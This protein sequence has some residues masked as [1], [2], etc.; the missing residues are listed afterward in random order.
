MM[1]D[2]LSKS[3]YLKIISEY[4]YLMKTKNTLNGCLLSKLRGTTGLKTKALS[5]FVK[6]EG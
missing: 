6:E 4:L 3:L 2:L 5:A 1:I